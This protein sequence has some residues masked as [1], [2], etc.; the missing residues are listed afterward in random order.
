MHRFTGEIAASAVTPPMNRV[1]HIVTDH[2]L[3]MKCV[4]HERHKYH[5]L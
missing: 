1:C 2:D 4:M 5:P 3:C